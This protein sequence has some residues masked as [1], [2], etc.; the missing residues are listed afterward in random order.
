M[1]QA[2]NLSATQRLDAAWYPEFEGEWDAR[3]FRQRVLKVIGPE[4]RMLDI[5]AGRGATPHMQ[6]KGMVAEL[7]GVDVDPVVLTNTQVDRAVHTP[8][9]LLTALE[10]DYFDVV[11]SKDVLEHVEHPD[12]LFAEIARVLKPGGLLLAKTPNGTH[13]VPVIARLTPLSLHKT[14][15]KL[16][17]RDVV[18]TFPTRYRAN[19]RK[20][21]TRLATQSGLEVVAV[22]FQEGRPEYLRFHPLTY[23]VGMAYERMVNA[24]GL[25]ALKAVIFYVT[26]RKSVNSS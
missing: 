18:D 21:L 12:V 6:Y 15:N 5:G 2:A 20:A 25:N 17:G 14:F 3:A 24:L 1:T 19:S 22:E 26:L 7:V 4:T 10:S 23:F 9:G 8:D 16:R 11:I 13:Y